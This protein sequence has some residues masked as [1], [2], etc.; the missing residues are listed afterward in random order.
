MKRFLKTRFVLIICL[1]LGFGLTL[2]GVAQAQD[3]Q[4]CGPGFWKQDHHVDFWVG[5]T[6]ELLFFTIFDR[7]IEIKFKEKGTKGKPPPLGDPTLI[8]ALWAKGGGES[9]LARQAVAAYLNASSP[10]INYADTVPEVIAAVQDAIDSGDTSVIEAQKDL[11]EANNELG[12]PLNEDE[13]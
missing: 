11:F 12:C 7:E 2:S 6:P 8:E 1:T 3:F 5:V 10:L 9:A 4:G 13:I